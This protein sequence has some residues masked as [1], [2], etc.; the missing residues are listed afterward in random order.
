MILFTEEPYP[1]E[2]HT[3]IF[4]EKGVYMEFACKLSGGVDKCRIDTRRFM[5]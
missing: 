1:S 3:E 4:K 2:I 5:S